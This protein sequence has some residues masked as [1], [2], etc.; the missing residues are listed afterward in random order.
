M[1]FI[2]QARGRRAVPASLPINDVDQSIAPS[3]STC[4]PDGFQAGAQARH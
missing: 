3:E 4:I 1:R 2:V